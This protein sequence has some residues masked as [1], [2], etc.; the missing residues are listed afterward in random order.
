MENINY[1]V[2]SYNVIKAEA[3]DVIRKSLPLE[4]CRTYHKKYNKLL[5]DSKFAEFFD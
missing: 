1:L 2:L 4:S 3:L 5:F